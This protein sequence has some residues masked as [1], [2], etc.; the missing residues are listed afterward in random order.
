MF[1]V[2]GMKASLIKHNRIVEDEN[3]YDDKNYETVTIKVCPYNT[4]QGVR[5]GV[6]THPE[7]SGYYIVNRTVDVREGDQIIF[8]NGR[9]NP[10]IKNK[11][12]SILKVSDNWIYNRVENKI[13]AVK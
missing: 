6:Y 11:T 13:I 9:Q 4:N 3:Y 10:A 8:I 7:A 12:H 5:F 1:L 2:N